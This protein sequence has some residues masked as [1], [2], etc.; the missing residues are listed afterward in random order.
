MN[1]TGRVL[2][3]GTR[4]AG[5]KAEFDEAGPDV[6]GLRGA[7][8]AAYRRLQEQGRVPR[9]ARSMGVRNIQGARS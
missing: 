5:R 9:L 7:V 1:E 3:K 2:H 6:R 8:D 4:K